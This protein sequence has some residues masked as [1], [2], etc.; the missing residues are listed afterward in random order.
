M[1][2]TP[3]IW[4]MTEDD[5]LTGLLEL[6]GLLGWRVYHVRRSDKA[7]IQ[8]VGGAGFPVLMGIDPHTKRLLVIE[9]KSDIGSRRP[10][11][12]HGYSRSV[13]TQRSRRRSSVLRPMTPRSRRSAASVPCRTPAYT[14]RA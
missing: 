7:I 1:T 14:S 6:M 11:S 5:L 9:C 8:G 10:I 2:A 12:S 13:I 4:P 3:G